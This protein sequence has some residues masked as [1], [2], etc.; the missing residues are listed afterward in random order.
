M[1]FVIGFQSVFRF[2]NVSHLYKLRFPSLTDTLTCWLTHTNVALRE[3]RDRRIRKQYF[4]LLTSYPYHRFLLLLTLFYWY[5]LAPPSIPIPPQPAKKKKEEASLGLL[6]KSFRTCCY[7]HHHLSRPLL[8]TIY[9]NFNV[10]RRNAIFLSWNL[11]H[12]IIKI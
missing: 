9:F 1:T 10:N 12:L 4:P 7:I 6:A 3:S 11:I 2:S 8:P 5:P